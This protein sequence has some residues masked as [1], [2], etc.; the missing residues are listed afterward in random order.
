MERSLD[1]QREEFARR[2]FLAMPLAGT[3]AWGAVLV[4]ALVLEPRWLPLVLFLATGMIA[5]LGIALSRLTG[6]NFLDRSRPR[7]AFDALFMHSVGMA[8][9]VYAIAIPFFL[10]QPDSLPLSVGILT[11]LMW[12]PFSWI[13]GH[14]IGLLHAITRTAGI[15]AAW[16]AFPAQRYVAVSLVI[17]AVYAITI[18][19][20]ES[21]WRGL[22]TAHAG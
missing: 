19:V 13:I 22:R 1:A 15:V 6:E 18:A 16:Y 7:N 11:G 9:L 4:A 8:V 14:W 21:R 17:I 10:V 2:R 5:Y 3:L 12:L 20:F